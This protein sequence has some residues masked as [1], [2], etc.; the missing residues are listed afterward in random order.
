MLKKDIK[1][2]KEIVEIPKEVKAEPKVVAPI[3]LK[4]QAPIELPKEEVKAIEPND[5]GIEINMPETQK[6]QEL[7]LVVKLPANASKAQIE[8]AKIINSYAYINPRKFEMKKD[9]MIKHLLSLKNAPDPIVG[10]L[11]INNSGI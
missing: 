1:A 3:E 7:P 11:K 10:N 2:E 4:P 9:A 6:V 5:Q 8:Y